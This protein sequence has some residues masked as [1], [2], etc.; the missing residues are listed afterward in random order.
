[1][2]LYSSNAMHLVSPSVPVVL[3]T[4]KAVMGAVVTRI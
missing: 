3:A 1:M 4:K 2:A